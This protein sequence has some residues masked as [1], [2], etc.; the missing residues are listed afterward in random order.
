MSNRNNENILVRELRSREKIERLMFNS[1]YSQSTVGGFQ[2]LLQLIG[3]IT[4]VSRAIY[5]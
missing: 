5:K 4:K 1:G 2:R 3:D